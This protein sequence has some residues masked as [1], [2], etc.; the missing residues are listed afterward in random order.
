MIQEHDFA[1]L[2]ERLAQAQA[3]LADQKQVGQDE[4]TREQL[5][6]RAAQCARMLR[7][8]LDRP[9]EMA[10][11]G[12]TSSGKSLLIGTLLG[13]PELLPDMKETPSTGNVT[14]LRLQPVRDG[15]Q[16][17]FVRDGP[18]GMPVAEV[19]LLP[20]DDIASLV[21][22]HVEG[23]LQVMSNRLGPDRIAALRAAAG[24][25]GLRTAFAGI[26]EWLQRHWT[27]AA[28]E[29]SQGAEIGGVGRGSWP[30]VRALLDLR[31]ACLAGGHLVGDVPLRVQAEP[32]AL[33]T[34]RP[35]P[36]K[37]DRFEPFDRQRL[38]RSA[39]EH[40][41]DA[42]V[43]FPIIQRVTYRVRVAW[44][45]NIPSDEHEVDVLDFPG[46]Y[47]GGSA[48]RDTFLSRLGLGSVHSVAMCVQAGAAGTAAVEDLHQIL[49]AAAPPGVNPIRRATLLATRFDA[50]VPPAGDDD[51]RELDN[52]KRLKLDVQTIAPFHG[53]RTTNVA[54]LEKAAGGPATN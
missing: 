48:V 26:D 44:W 22:E 16:P 23:V 33:L 49:E 10:F 42:G 53:N 15:E 28:E 46:L 9:L 3:A 50:F 47:G 29:G 12:P 21:K 27:S 35:P 40:G 11:V 32:G 31:D 30:A 24:R 51:F 54:E 36:R 19:A 18:S 2:R 34:L 17:G 39:L 4:T 1:E 8:A 6:R 13:C 43:L 52:I 14:A 25:P 7:N 37:P 38:D 20:A 5:P 45:D 41:Q